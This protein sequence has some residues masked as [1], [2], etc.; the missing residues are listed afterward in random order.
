M[1]TFCSR[2]TAPPTI[3]TTISITWHVSHTTA[4]I[5]EFMVPGRKHVTFV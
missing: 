4:A 3:T 5:Q 1:N 2:P